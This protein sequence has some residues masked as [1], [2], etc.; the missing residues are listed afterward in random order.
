MHLYQ[1]HTGVTMLSFWYACVWCPLQL[2]PSTYIRKTL[3]QMLV[4][5]NKWELSGSPVNVSGIPI[6]PLLS[7]SGNYFMY[8]PSHTVCVC[9]IKITVVHPINKCIVIIQLVTPTKISTYH[10]HDIH[11]VAAH[12]F[13]FS[14]S[15]Q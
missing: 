12:L 15:Q 7:V 1:I 8:T 10:H 14:M 11:A 6:I 13:K 5:C 4:S 9:L 3:Q 2:L